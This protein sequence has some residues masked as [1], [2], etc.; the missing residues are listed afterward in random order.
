MDPAKLIK[1]LEGTMSPEHSKEAE[2]RLKEMHKIVG[3][4]PLLLQIVMSQDVSMP[5]RQSGVIY[6]KNT[7]Q[8]SWCDKIDDNGCPSTEEFSIHENDRAVLRSNIVEAIVIA[9]DAVRSQLTV[10]ANIIIKNDYPQ[11]WPEVVQNITTQLQTDKPR[12]WMGALLTLY[13]L[14]KNFE[15]KKAEERGP[16]IEPMKVFLPVILQMF[17]KLMSDPSPES[18]LLQKQLIKITYAFIQYSLPLEIFNEEMVDQY[19]SVMKLV[20]EQP[21]PAETSQVDESERGDLPWWKLKKWAVR[22]LTRIFERYGS[23][24]SVV[25]EYTDFSEFYLKRYSVGVLQVVLKFLDQYRQKVYVAPRVVQISFQYLEHSINHSHTWKVLKTVYMDILKDVAYPLMCFMEED[26]DTWEDDPN[27][28]IRKK[29]SLYEDFLSPSTAAHS[30]LHCA[31]S[32]RKN[33]LQKT[34]GFCH[35]ILTAT[36][37]SSNPE[38]AKKKDG[39]LHMIGALS[40]NLLKRKLY[41]DQLEGMMKAH[42]LP[43]LK[44][45][46]GYMRARACWVVQNFSEARI[47]TQENIICIADTIK[48]LLLSDK[49][50]PVRVQAAGALS[51]FLSAQ[52]VAEKHCADDIRSIVQALLELV[53]STESDEL[54]NVVQRIICLYCEEVI[55]YAVEITENLTATFLSIVESISSEGEI[56]NGMGDEYMDDKSTMALGVL[57]AI[58][59][60]LEMMEEERDITMRLESIVAP[61]INAVLKNRIIDYYDEV[62]SLVYSLTCQK[63]SSDMW[64]ALN[65]VN[66]VFLD[67]GID[68]FVEMMPCLHNYCTVDTETLL[69][70]PKHL[71]TIYMM[72]KKVLEDEVGEDP[73][74]HAAKLMEVLILQ[75]KGQIDQV[76]PHFVETVLVRMTKEIRTTELRTICLQVVIAALYY[77]PPLLFQ[78]LDSIRLPNSPNSVGEQFFKQ[79]FSDIENFLG[80]HDRKMCIIGFCTLMSLESRPKCVDDFTPDTI[81]QLIKVFQGLIRAYKIKGEDEASSSDDSDEEV[82]QDDTLVEKQELADDEDE[83]D[84]DSAQYL[85]MLDKNGN[86]NPEFSVDSDE[87]TDLECFVT[88]LD[89]EGN[90]IIAEDFVDEFIH[91]KNVLTDARIRL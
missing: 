32:K 90:K 89:P 65:V 14:V 66:E 56:G 57:S 78:T 64:E 72:C 33:V 7:C 23:P 29:F 20:L 39:V 9:P 16:L 24:G 18:A 53:R 13:Q 43:E 2:G 35:S 4:T 38:I 45:Q 3:F 81:P 17:Q 73:E 80:I 27:E 55:P 74:C 47:G 31:C 62:F 88:K 12:A 63:I 25:K 91:F 59:T 8:K 60:V 77:S 28:Y 6:L 61:L 82:E 26:H 44:S 76:I 84:E 30:F 11:K 79:W 85:E 22:F 51:S 21:V 42:V 34:M 70:N 15:Y 83:I 68:Y 87:E 48:H 19:I 46:F 36:E 49:E 5:V 71:E 69:A 40:D 41:R 54:T 58:E 50:L 67:D 37:L 52:T 86:Y 1:I 10:I 75:C